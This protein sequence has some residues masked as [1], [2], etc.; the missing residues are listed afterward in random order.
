MIMIINFF[1]VWFL[2][3]VA[4]SLTSVIMGYKEKPI[5]II[6]FFA[7]TITNP[8]LNYIIMFIQLI[9]HGK[10]FAMVVLVLECLVVIT[11][12][13]ILAYVYPKRTR[14]LLVLS[15]VMNTVS[16]VVGLLVFGLG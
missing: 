4:E 7:N 2:T 11:E 12:W 15:L 6:I 16:Y 1:L 3:I 13:R 9:L 14:S 8:V 10:T 5:F